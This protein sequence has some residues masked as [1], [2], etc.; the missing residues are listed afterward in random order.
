MGREKKIA[1][2]ILGLLGMY[3]DGRSTLYTIIYCGYGE[4]CLILKFTMKC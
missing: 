4:K 3:A 2:D 1:K